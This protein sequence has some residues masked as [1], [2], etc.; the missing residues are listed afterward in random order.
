MAVP[1]LARVVNM[2]VADATNRDGPRPAVGRTVVSWHGWAR[3]LRAWGVALVVSAAG[4]AA[5]YDV[6]GF[7]AAANNRFSSGFPSAPV[8]NTSGSFVGL[9]YSW[10]GVGWAAS[11]P[12]KGFGFLTPK[13]YLVARH[14]GG[15]ATITLL[16]AGGQ[17]VTGT[18]ASVTDTGYGFVQSGQTVGDISIGELTAPLATAV[19]LPRYGVLDANTSSTTNSTYSGQPLMVY[20]RGPD[21]TQSP[22]MGVATVGGAYAWSV[23]GST[24]YIGSTVATGTL[25]SGD[26]GSPTFIRWTNPNGAAEI[27]IIGNNA[28]SDFATV[29]VYNFLG[30]AA[31]MNAINALTTPDGY[32]LK[33][34]GTPTNTWVGSSSTSIGNRGAWGLS[35]PTPAP[36]DKY[37]LFSGTSAGNG[38]AVTMD[39]AANLRGLFFKSTGSGTLGFTFSGTATLTVGRGGITN[40]DTS[41]Q[42]IAAPITLGTSQ[43]WNVGPGGVTAAAVNTGTTGFLLEIDGSGTARIAGPISGA[44]G[45]ALSGQRLELSG[46]NSFSGG[47]WVHAGTLSIGHAAALQAS[48]VRVASGGTLAVAGYLDPTVA[49]LGLAAGGLVD[50]GNGGMTV[51][52]GLSVPSLV[53]ALIAGRDDG[54]WTG[55]SGITSAAVAADVALGEERAVGWLDNGDGSVSFAYAAP[56]DSNLDGL[57]DTLDTANFLGGGKFD[58]VEPSSWIEGDFNYDGL[59]DILDAASF[60][61][62]GLF[63]AGYYHQPPLAFGAA[64]AGPAAPVAVVPEPAGLAAVAVAGLVA[65]AVARRR[66]VCSS[67]S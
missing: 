5:A 24:S 57:V 12:T 50:V 16:A 38:R 55:T 47:A 29:N 19:G 61:S 4:S 54:S 10:L 9:P 34:V 26:S 67:G 66:G 64:L 40:Y 28:A 46:S 7:T 30:A 8:T 49:G 6:V 36:S 53:A 52:A 59:V 33:I 62:T 39:T 43:M 22:R 44:G 45:L 15:A 60:V 14:Y 3:L 11:D 20:G 58:V 18:Q 21:G 31:V 32:A 37:V 13:H 17:V 35:P 25:Q 48:V 63:D 51:T 56:G 2:P 41:R 23:S 27:T 42:T 1:A 65:L